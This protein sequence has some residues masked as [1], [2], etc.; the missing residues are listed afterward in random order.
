LSEEEF[1][2][3][4]Q[5]SE[6]YDNDLKLDKQVKHRPRQLCSISALQIIGMEE[7]QF[8]VGELGWEVKEEV[9]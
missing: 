7:A 4:V 8:C 9:L 3:D 2:L 1:G 6:E 5:S